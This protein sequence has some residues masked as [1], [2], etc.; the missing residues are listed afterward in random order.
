LL[1]NAVANGLDAA[2]VAGMEKDDA[3]K[4]LHG[5]PMFNALVAQAGKSIVA[6]QKN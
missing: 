6:A 1:Q 4:S 3:L 5:N 2:T